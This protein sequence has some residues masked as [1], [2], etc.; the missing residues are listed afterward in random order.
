MSDDNQY[1]ALANALSDVGAETG[2]AEAHGMLC[3]M[4]STPGETEQARWI[5]E[6]LA[7]TEP[8]GEPAR[9]CLQLLS[10]LFESTR[11]EFGDDGMGFTPLL[12]DDDTALSERAGALGAWCEGYVFG[13][14]LGGLSSREELPREA[15]EVVND[16]SEIAR[17]DTESDTGDEGEEAYTELV[18]YVRTGAMLVR[19][20][21]AAPSRAAPPAVGTTADDSRE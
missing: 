14:G 15:G 12:P 18:E 17:V 10:G 1:A 4:L 11:S 6:V 7:H 3:G 16:F 5:A 13:L 2:A 8:K 21:L 19:E 20:N 9:D